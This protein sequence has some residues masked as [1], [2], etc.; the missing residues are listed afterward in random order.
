MTWS[1]VKIRLSTGSKWKAY[2]ANCRDIDSSVRE[3]IGK[4]QDVA[5]AERVMQITLPKSSV[6]KSTESLLFSHSGYEA[7]RAG[8]ESGYATVVE[9]RWT[10]MSGMIAILSRPDQ[11]SYAEPSLTLIEISRGG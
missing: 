8:L 2:D 4:N 3:R 5:T 1:S 10:Q 11:E 9:S 7:I 6:S